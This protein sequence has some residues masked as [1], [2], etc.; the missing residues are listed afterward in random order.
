M[1]GEA[2]LEE[3]GYG[4][5]PSGEGWFV[6]NG[7]D[8]RWRH[9]EGRGNS[10]PFTG[11]SDAEAE[12]HFPQLGVN[13]LV[14]GPG[15]PIGMYHWEA[16]QEGFLV[17]SG[18]ALLIVEGQERPLRQWDFVH[19]P[20]ETRHMIVGAGTRPCVVLA[21]GAREHMDE[22]CNGGAY[23]VDKVALR[24]GAGVEEETNDPER[25]Y[26]GFSEP[27]PTPYRHGWLPGG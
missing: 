27:E 26:A 4:L 10:L 6:L 17:L 11:W 24:H 23:I 16:D 20:P 14:L 2:K 12:A 7:R 13:L 8:A 9:R 18:E 25:A 21:V 3:T 22:N 15:E 5:A 1:V 19:C